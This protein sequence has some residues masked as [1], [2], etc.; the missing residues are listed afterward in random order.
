LPDR[1]TAKLLAGGVG[2]AFVLK[3]R[4]TSMHMAVS[5]YVSSSPSL[6]LPV[7]VAKGL[8]TFGRGVARLS[9]ASAAVANIFSLHPL[10][11]SLRIFSFFA[12]GIVSSISTQEEVTYFVLVFV[13]LFESE[14]EIIE[15]N[16]TAILSKGSTK[17]IKLRTLSQALY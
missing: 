11:N 8:V 2:A 9:I 16:T 7:Y 12:Y 14:L 5:G 13:F 10:A 1:L 4:F 17:S 3:K 15:I 6:S